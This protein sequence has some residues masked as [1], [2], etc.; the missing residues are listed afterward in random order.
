MKSLVIA[1]ALVLSSVALAQPAGSLSQSKDFPLSEFSK[2]R[3][4]IDEILLRDDIKSSDRATCYWIAEMNSEFAAGEKKIYALIDKAR[5][6]NDSKKAEAL[7]AFQAKINSL[8]SMQL[9]KRFCIGDASSDE[10]VGDRKVLEENLRAFQSLL[11]SA[12]KTPSPTK[13]APKKDSGS[14]KPKH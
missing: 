3:G 10:V 8:D 11:E 12:D 4:R 2:V 9:V 6:K 1:T 13:L 14:G 5:A 7:I